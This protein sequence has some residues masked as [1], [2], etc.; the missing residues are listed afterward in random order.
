MQTVFM[1]GNNFKYYNMVAA[2]Y[3][4]C[5]TCTKQKYNLVQQT[6]AFTDFRFDSAACIPPAY[7][8]GPVP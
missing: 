7:L 1:T 3:Y 5:S 2:A 4:F 8:Q 6:T